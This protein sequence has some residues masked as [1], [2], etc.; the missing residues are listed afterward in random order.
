LR[1][2]KYENGVFT[3]FG[4]FCSCECAAAYIM[5]YN[6]YCRA[7]EQY[8]LLN[9]MNNIISKNDIKKK[10]ELAPPRECLNIFGG[11]M[12]IE[13]FRNNN[14]VLHNI[15]NY[16]MIIVTPQ[17]EETENIEANF[18]KSIANFKT[19]PQQ[20]ELRL[21]RSKPLP[22]HKMSITNCMEAFTKHKQ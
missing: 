20:S 18:S 16:P 6:D 7:W 3:V 15:I 22:N 17:I 9:T 5:K 2:E 12:D 4:C 11:Y 21:K 8:S 1:P 14:N 10:I 19:N 13:K